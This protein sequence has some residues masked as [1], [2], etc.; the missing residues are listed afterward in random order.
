[1]YS[2]DGFTSID[3]SNSLSVLE[4]GELRLY[5][6]IGMAIGVIIYM[7]LFSKKFIKLNVSIIK[8]IKKIIYKVIV[9][10]LNKIYR[11]IIKI[12]KPITFFVINLKKIKF[13]S[14]KLIKKKDFKGECRKI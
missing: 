12:I 9:L 8:F 3:E 14:K 7:L 5:N 1:M 13:F 10:P 2:I 4:N 6:F 11:G